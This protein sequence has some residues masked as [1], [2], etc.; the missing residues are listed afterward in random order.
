MLQRALAYGGRIEAGPR[1]GP[2]WQVHAHLP[3]S[4]DSAPA[5]VGA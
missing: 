5:E 2:G 3:F 1:T 4:T